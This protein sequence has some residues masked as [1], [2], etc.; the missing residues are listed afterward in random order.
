[1]ATQ[2]TVHGAT[3]KLNIEF[4]TLD[5]DERIIYTTEIMIVAGGDNHK[6]TIFS[7]QPLLLEVKHA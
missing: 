5:V 6:V 7:E 2:Y 1:M 4:D 3:D